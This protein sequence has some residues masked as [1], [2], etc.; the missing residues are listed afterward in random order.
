MARA[1]EE[2]LAARG[3][4]CRIE[5]VN[6]AGAAH[7]GA[8]LAVWALT[9]SGA[10][11]GA[12]RA[13]APRRSSEAIGRFVAQRLLADLASGASCDRHTADQLVLFAAL[14]A[15]ESAY[16][17]PRTTEHLTTNLWLAERFGAKAELD[18]A[19]VVV[20]GLAR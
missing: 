19:R 3:L 4:E 13:G 6:D 15:G 18:G 7:A 12:D 16:R 8:S 9:S 1:C 17:V 11:L 20:Q 14:A 5:R 10:R 2:K